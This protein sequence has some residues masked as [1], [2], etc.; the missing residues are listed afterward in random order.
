[1]CS[2]T[3]NDSIVLCIHGDWNCTKSFA[4]IMTWLAHALKYIY[5]RVILYLR[6]MYYCVYRIWLYACLATQR[7][8][9]IK[10]YICAHI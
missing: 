6:S 8:H 7:A 5:N 2:L 9:I 10:Y 3:Y 4:F 1:M